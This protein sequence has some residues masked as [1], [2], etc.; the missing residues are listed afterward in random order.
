[1]TL[2]FAALIG[3]ELLT[4]IAIFGAVACAA[5]LMM[6]MFAKK[7]PR[8]EQRLEDF[9]DPSRRR[10]GR[11]GSRGVTKRSDG[12]A[13]LLELASPKFSKPLQPKSEEDVGKLRAKLNYAGF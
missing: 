10:D 12:M 9:R 2:I 7:S 4:K 8:V 13:R 11:D 1:M 6:E 3:M 5:W